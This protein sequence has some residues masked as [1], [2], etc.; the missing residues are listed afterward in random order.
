[1]DLDLDLDLGREATAT[2]RA[3]ALSS[4]LPGGHYTGHLRMRRGAGMRIARRS[5]VARRW[6]L[7]E[8]R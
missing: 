5:V 6:S 3:G 8:G 1:M 7:E 2:C 4:M